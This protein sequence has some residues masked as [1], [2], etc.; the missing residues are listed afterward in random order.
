M[1]I[2][3]C[4]AS[5]P[6][7][8]FCHELA[9]FCHPILGR[10]QGDFSSRWHLWPSSDL[11]C[12][13]D[14]SLLLLHPRTWTEQGES[15]YF[16]RMCSANLLGLAESPLSEGG[17][18]ARICLNRWCQLL[19][20]PFCGPEQEYVLHKLPTSSCSGFRSELEVTW[21]VWQIKNFLPQVRPCHHV[22]IKVMLLHS[23]RNNWF[24]LSFIYVTFF[25]LT[26]KLATKISVT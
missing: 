13:A 22:S 12:H 23:H 7:F 5:E 15:W 11:R 16:Q 14:S 10:I 1:C 19:F 2:G 9:W 24:R 3:N 8:C 4:N 17:G 20:S 18:E 6:N 21:C 26:F 25:Y